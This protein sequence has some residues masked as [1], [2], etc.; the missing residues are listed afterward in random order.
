[1]NCL[2]CGKINSYL[3]DVDSQ[4]DEI[5][6]RLVKQMAEREGVPEQLKADK[7]ME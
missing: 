2:T 5:L 3:A 7:Q 4:A 6:S 1:M